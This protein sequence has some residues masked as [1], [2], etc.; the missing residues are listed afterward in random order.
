MDNESPWLKLTLESEMLFHPAR[1]YLSKVKKISGKEYA[2]KAVEIGKEQAA[3]SEIPLDLVRMELET[4]NRIL[5]PPRCFR[6]F[7]DVGEELYAVRFPYAVGG[8]SIY[9][10]FDRERKLV[11]FDND[12]FGR[13]VKNA[14][15]HEQDANNTYPAEVEVSAR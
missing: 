1:E 12:N 3:A 9:A 7:P 4:G 13:F 5:A 15:W 14:L 10:L 11:F 8:V 2:I 6:R